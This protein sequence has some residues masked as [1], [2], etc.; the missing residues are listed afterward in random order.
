MFSSI[1]FSISNSISVVS[2]SFFRRGKFSLFH[3]LLHWVKD[4]LWFNDLSSAHGVIL[5][6]MCSMSVLLV[7]HANE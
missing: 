6:L 5:S 1:S 7:K 2:Y 3:M 4:A